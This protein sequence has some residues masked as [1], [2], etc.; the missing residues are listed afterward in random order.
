MATSQGFSEEFRVSS[1]F[2]L[3]FISTIR[4]LHKL[5]WPIGHW[6]TFYILGSDQLPISHG[7][8][9]IFRALVTYVT[10]ADSRHRLPVPPIVTNFTR[11]SMG[12]QHLSWDTT[13]PI[14]KK[15]PS[16]RFLLSIFHLILHIMF[17]LF[18]Y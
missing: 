7:R 14:D 16:R 6:S 17:V 1:N 12:R 2:T 4:E 5:L 10:L 9:L 3:F 15:T 8:S 11:N 13:Y 18:F